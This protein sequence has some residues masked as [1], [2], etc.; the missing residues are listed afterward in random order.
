MSVI[1]L[2]R[3]GLVSS[4]E[5]IAYD[6]NIGRSSLLLLATQQQDEE[7]DENDLVRM[8]QEVSA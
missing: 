5:S 3:D 7:E 4:V 1:R 6:P 2:M 8:I